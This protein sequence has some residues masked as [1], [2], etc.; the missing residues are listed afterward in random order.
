VTDFPFLIDSR[1]LIRETAPIAYRRR[2]AVLADWP[3]DE[4]L[5]I[6][7]ILHRLTVLRV[8]NPEDAEDLVQ[9]TLLTMAAKCPTLDLQKSLLIWGMGILRRKVGNYYRRARRCVSLENW[10]DFDPRVRLPSARDSPESRLIEAELSAL[11]EQ[12]MLTLTGKERHAIQLHLDGLPTAEIVA[13]LLPERYQNVVN[14]LHRGRR[15]IALQ[16]ARHGYVS[17]GRKRHTD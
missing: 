8:E 4:L 5:R 16:L 2:P 14:R 15:K 13:R 12:T 3:D 10:E 7:T 17:S 11:L 6:R 9:E 1:F